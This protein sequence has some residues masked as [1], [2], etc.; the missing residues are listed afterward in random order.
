MASQS[1][2]MVHKRIQNPPRQRCQNFMAQVVGWENHDPTTKSSSI[3]MGHYTQFHLNVGPTL[4]VLCRM[5]IHAQDTRE[6]R[7]CFNIINWEGQWLG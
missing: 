7:I 5:I 6:T 2:V 3:T 1:I 4:I